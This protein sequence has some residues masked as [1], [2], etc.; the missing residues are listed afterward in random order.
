MFNLKMPIILVNFKAYLEGTGERGMLIAKAAER[1]W[2]ETGITVG[3]APPSTDIRLLASSTNIPIFAQH[4]DSVSPGSYTGKITAEA[5]K[6]AG[7]I[8]TLLNHSENRLQIADLQIGVERARQ[9]GLITVV[10]TNNPLVSSACAAL[11]PDFIAIEPPELIGTGIPVSKA[12]PEVVTS[13]I[14]AI[15]KVNSS[16]GVICGA[17]IS[18][19][20]DVSAA[21]KLGT[22][23]VLLASGVVKAKD[24]E[25]VLLDMA[26]SAKIQASL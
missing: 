14:E 18:K 5:V 1:V 19:G 17:G 4:I 13:S 10:C 25:T 23:G 8:G 11:G 7:A 15:K 26:T 2:M 21:I 24:P 3:V 12:K 20:E 9:L 6:D 16:V 22:S